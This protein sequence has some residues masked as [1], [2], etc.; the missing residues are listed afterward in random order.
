MYLDKAANELRF[1]V[2]D[3]DGTAERPGI[4]GAD[5]DTAGWHHVAGV[6]D[7][8]TGRAMIYLDGA[9]K[10]THTN[11]ALT[12]Q[13]KTGQVAALGRDGIMDRFF[14]RGAL[15]DVRVYDRALDA[16]ELSALAARAPGIAVSPTS[17]LTTTE[18]GTTAAFSVRLEAAPAADVTI[19]L[20]PSDPSEGSLS[21]TSL[22]FTPLNWRTPQTVTVT[23]LDDQLPDGT[24]AYSVVLAP[25]VSADPAYN[26]IDG[27][28]V[29]VVNRDN[30]SGPSDYIAYWRLDEGAGFVA[31]DSAGNA[32]GTLA[33]DIDGTVWTSPAAPTTFPNAFALSFDGVDGRVA[34]PSGG[35]LNLPGNSVTLSMWFK[36]NELPSGIS[37][38]TVAG[39]F[40]A[41]Q[42]AYVMYL[43]K[44]ANELRFKVTDLDGTAERPGISAA[45]LD[46]TAWHHVAGVYDGST[47]RAMIYLDGVLKDTHINAALTARV[48][49]GQVAAMGRDGANNRFYFN[50][51]LDDVRIFDRA[52][53][54]VEI[55]DIGSPIGQIPRGPLVLAVASTPPASS[56]VDLAEAQPAPAPFMG[57]A[58]AVVETDW[59]RF[60]EQGTDRPVVQIATGQPPAPDGAPTLPTV[61]SPT[62]FVPDSTTPTAAMTAK[63]VDPLFTALADVDVV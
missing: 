24:V 28:D 22:V 20:A 18:A 26:G 17:G 48:K 21:T 40:D 10:D 39:L 11:A 27:A 15:D 2:T 38:E 45:D 34:L 23:G 51:S 19:N 25:A 31:A 42:D 53:S 61:V 29:A 56:V 46:T 12:G 49:T 13:V 9:L 63:Q 5:L 3:A 7:G 1:K 4:A 43:D 60:V 59:V 54:A 6:Y 14:F 44:A 30:D 36:L 33:G 62:V 8:S 35:A 55:A 41:D 57:R 52:L 58:A 47:G 50:G 37:G 32:H 16:A